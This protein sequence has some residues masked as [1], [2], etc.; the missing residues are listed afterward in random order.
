MKF[1]FLAFTLIFFLTSCQDLGAFDFPN[2][3]RI[4]GPI[5]RKTLINFQK[6][7]KENEI[8]N[9]ILESPGGIIDYSIE[10]ADLV[11]SENINTIV[12]RNK[13]CSS[14]CTIIYQAG[15]NRY[16]SRASKFVYHTARLSSY[17][18]KRFFRRC[19]FPLSENCQKT[20]SRYMK[21]L[22]QQNER[23]KQHL[24]EN[25]L[26]PQV[27]NILMEMSKMDIETSYKRGNLYRIPDLMITGELLLILNIGTEFT[28]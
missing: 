14:A 9:L 11:K 12:L 1:V 13:H 20:L 24:E 16:L 15:K 2:S 18:T 8:K 23:M 17:S 21:Y 27:F 7:V 28:D 4:T 26:N 6:A 3:Y 25:G 22:V 10:I 5:D 19:D